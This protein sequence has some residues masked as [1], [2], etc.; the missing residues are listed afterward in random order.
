MQLPGRRFLARKWFICTL[1]GS[2]E[3]V[4]Q[5]IEGPDGDIDRIIG[6]VRDN[7]AKISNRL[8]REIPALADESLAAEVATAILLALAQMI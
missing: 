2:R 8:I 7:G 1:F 3:R 4:K 5:V 6:S